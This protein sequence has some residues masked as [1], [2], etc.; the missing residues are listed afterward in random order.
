MLKEEKGAKIYYHATILGSFTYYDDPNDD[1]EIRD[2]IMNDMQIDPEYIDD[3][4]YWIEDKE[5][6]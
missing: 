3:L 1:L 2:K 4:E 5:E 6:E